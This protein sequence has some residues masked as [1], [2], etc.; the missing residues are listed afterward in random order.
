V[1]A[2]AQGDHKL[3]RGYMP[4]TTYS[5]HYILDPNFREAIDD[6]LE[7]ERQHVEWEKQAIAE[8]APFRKAGP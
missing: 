1:E 2:G 5:A 6:Y 7:R 4:T 8:H 3:A